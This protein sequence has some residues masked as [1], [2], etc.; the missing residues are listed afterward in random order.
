MN[1]AK[2]IIAAQ[3]RASLAM[4]RQAMELCPDDLW[5]A[6]RHDPPFWRIAYHTLFFTDLYAS[7]EAG[8]FAPWDQHVKDYE[9]IDPLASIDCTPYTKDDLLAYTDRLSGGIVDRLEPLDMSGPSGMP[10][11]PFSK[12]E[13]QFYNIRHIHHHT[14]QLSTWLREEANAE[15]DWVGSA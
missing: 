11:L 5:T 3:Y 13:L 2:P 12:L 14:G 8:I 6:S 15:L 9:S 4:F 1:D 10:W 7:E